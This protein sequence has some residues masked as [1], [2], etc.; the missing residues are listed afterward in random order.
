MG[1]RSPWASLKVVGWGAQDDQ[2]A[3][4]EIVRLRQERGRLLQKIRGLEQH[5]ERRKQEVGGSRDTG[6]GLNLGWVPF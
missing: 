5:Q 2:D 4:E 3:Y 1:G 6:L